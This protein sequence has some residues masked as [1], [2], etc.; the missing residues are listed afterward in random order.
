MNVTKEVL[1]NCEVLM[2]VEVD[3]QRKA[4]LLQNAARRISKGVKI[5]GFRPGKA[6][7][8]YIVNRFGIEALQ[9]EAM[10][11]L[12]KD[13][14]QEAIKAA[15]ITPFA[16]GSLD[17]IA[18]EPLVM[19]VKIPVA[20]VVEL[21]DYKDIRLEMP[22][23]EVSDEKV[24]KQLEEMRE[25]YSTYTP[26]GRPAQM[27]DLVSVTLT[28]KDEATGEVV[29]E[30]EEREI[31]MVEGDTAE[32]GPDF[33]KPLLGLSVGEETTF[34]F[35]YPPSVDN[36]D[37]E[38]GQ[39]VEI[40]LKVNAVKAKEAL[41]LGDDFAA[42]VGDYDSLDALKAKIKED[43]AHQEEHQAE[44]KLIDQMVDRLISEAKVLKWPQALEE[45]ELDAVLERQ[46]SRVKQMGIDFD[47]LLKYQNKT[48]EAAREELREGVK[49]N[50]RRSLVL[51]K[52]AE[53]EDVKVEAEEIMHQME[54]MVAYAGGTKEAVQMFQSPAAVS[55]LANNMLAEKAGHRLLAIAKGE[56][57]KVELPAEAETVAEE[58]SA[59]SPDA[60]SA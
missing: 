11:E 28:E 35:V 56:T 19:K 30:A 45:D 37:D 40:T 9:E 32:E 21:S 6:P 54:M 24:T 57:E 60:P 4:K 49:Q 5:P 34:P 3:E 23:I 7:Y 59:D 58:A 17:S 42:L 18:W 10:E 53:L 39:K 15:D 16:L 29:E 26:V 8:N 22:E 12:T 2:T 55:V 33:V 31:N 46:A 36:T 41:E 27:G 47:T 25:R 44:H 1:D 13:V 14:F 48:R 52:V 20:P 43:L 38:E 51:N 50:L